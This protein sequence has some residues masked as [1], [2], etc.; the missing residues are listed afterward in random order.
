M[1]SSVACNT[2]V[3]S[4]PALAKILRAKPSFC[5]RRAFIKCSDCTTCC[6][7]ILAASIAPAIPSHAISVKS[8]G[9]IWNVSRYLFNFRNKNNIPHFIPISCVSLQINQIPPHPALTKRNYEQTGTKFQM[10]IYEISPN[11][12]QKHENVMLFIGKHGIIP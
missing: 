8:D 6:L 1:K 4:T 7:L 9:V 3:L 11:S 10:S 5:S 2:D 12:R